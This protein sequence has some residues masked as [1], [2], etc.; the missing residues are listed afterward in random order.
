[1]RKLTLQKGHFDTFVF[2]QVTTL[3]AANESEFETALRL[4]KK[5]KDPALTK[6]VALT[7][8]EQEAEKQG[9]RAFPFRQLLEDEATFVLEEDEYQLLKKRVEKHKTLVA[10]L[11]LE[12]FAELLAVIA[13]AE[14]YN[15]QAASLKEE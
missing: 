5:L 10:T 3:P 15:I 14:T 6:E 13:G 1:M 8:E 11:V 2:Q 4:L 12:E 7:P 9:Q